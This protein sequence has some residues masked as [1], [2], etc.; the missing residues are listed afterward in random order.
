MKTYVT[1]GAFSAIASALLSLLLYF[2]GYQ[3]EKLATGQNF[4]WISFAIFILILF[5][6]MRD[7][8]ENKPN[9]AISYGAAVGAATMIALFAGLFGAVYN[10]IH[11]TFINTDYMQYLQD[12]TRSTL[13]AKNIPDAQIEAQLSIQAKFGTPLIQSILIV[14]FSPVLGALIGLVLAIFVKKAPPASEIKAS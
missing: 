11:L 10:Y 5:L 13:E 4:Q 9:K 6:G 7:A 1:Y 2:T 14:I 8:R 3:T 12:L